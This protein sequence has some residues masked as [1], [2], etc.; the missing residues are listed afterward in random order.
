M[1]LRITKR[2]KRKDYVT[3]IIIPRIK[4]QTPG[5]HLVEDFLASTLENLI[6]V[7]RKNVQFRWVH[8]ANAG[9]GLGYRGVIPP[10]SVRDTLWTYTA[11]ILGVC[12]ALDGAR[13]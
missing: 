4:G 2:R 7:E 5:A 6:G 9:M 8:A 10:L 1:A 3:L 11:E 12:D 13:A